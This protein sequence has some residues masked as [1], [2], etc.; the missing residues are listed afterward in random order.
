MSDLQH[1]ETAVLGKRARNVEETTD[2]VT[3]AAAL[4]MEDGSDD[5]DDVGPMPMPV[6]ATT[7]GS[8]KKKRKGLSFPWLLSCLIYKTV[9]Y[10]L[11]SGFSWIICPA[12]TNITR[13][14]CTA[15]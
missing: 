7:N 3:A 4:G 12:R 6:D 11:M 13:V 1:R 9:K 8:I 2:A 10:S 5:D 14:S 15:T